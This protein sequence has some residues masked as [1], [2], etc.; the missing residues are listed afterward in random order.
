MVIIFLD[1]L[2]FDEIFLLAQVKRI[3]IISN[4][5]IY[6]VYT[7]CLTS[8]L[9]LLKPWENRKYQELKTS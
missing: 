3:V 7:S 1:Y 4:I 6:M 5:R 8:F 2:M 9:F